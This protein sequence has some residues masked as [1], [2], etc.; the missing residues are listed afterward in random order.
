MESR[1]DR[2]GPP[3]DRWWQEPLSYVVSGRKV[4]LVGGAAA[5][6]TAA[7][8]RLRALGARDLLVVATEGAQDVRIMP[9][10]EG[11]AT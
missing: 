7:I 3:D 6:W 8:G 5:G 1:S 10:L 4:V 11:I 2:A 9:F